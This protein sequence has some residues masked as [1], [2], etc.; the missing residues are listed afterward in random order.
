VR[1][2][3]DLGRRSLRPALPALAFLYFYRLGMGIYVTLSD[4]S[5]TEGG[6]DAV[7][8]LLP[9]IAK[10]GSF[11]PLLV[12]IYTPFLPL[13][14]DLLRGRATSFL[15]SIRR[16][17]EMSWEFMLSGIVQGI[18]LVLPFALLAIAGGII[19]RIVAAGADTMTQRMM[20]LW[21]VL[22]G[23][24]VWFLVAGAFLMFA[25]PAVVLDR[26]GP[27]QSVRTSVSLVGRHLGG[28]FGRLLVFGFLTTMVYFV[29]LTPSAIIGAVERTSGSP[30]QALEIAGLVWSS[31]VDSLLFPYWVA[32]L[33]VLYRALVPPA[34][35]GH[36]AVRR[37]AEEEI[38]GPVSPAR[39]PFE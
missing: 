21:L 26:E 3:L 13:Q 19:L 8:A 39:I 27:V 11:L 1:A 18:I 28:I 10:I 14:D 7:G 30:S 16:V 25:T 9:Q 34:G 4:S 22:L 24:V 23:G 38:G 20:V 33:M 2:I 6:A 29:A 15:A 12:L 31:A 5:Y 17:L 37:S 36:A 32:A 35:E